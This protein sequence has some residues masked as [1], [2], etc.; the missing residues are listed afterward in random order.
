LAQEYQ[1]K[2]HH[3]VAVLILKKKEITDQYAKSCFRKSNLLGS[4]NGMLFYIIH[5]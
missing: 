2:F 3:Q 1:S 4:A 5:Q